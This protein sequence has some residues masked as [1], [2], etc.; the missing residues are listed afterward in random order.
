[1]AYVLGGKVGLFLPKENDYAYSNFYSSS[2]FFDLT[3]KGICAKS[4]L[5]NKPSHVDHIKVSTIC[6]WWKISV[7]I[8]KANENTQRR[9]KVLF[10]PMILR[11]GFLFLFCLLIALLM[12]MFNSRFP[13][14]E[15]VLDLAYNENVLYLTNESSF[16]L[17]FLFYFL[18]SSTWAS[19][20]SPSSL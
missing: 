16:L 12:L 11:I 4:N 13:L 15:F 19:L 2:T 1:M 17:Q 20:S 6:R 18:L 7:C 5:C 3:W 9:S 10:L 14:L 8:N